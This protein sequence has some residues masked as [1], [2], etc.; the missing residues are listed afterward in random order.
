MPFLTPNRTLGNNSGNNYLVF[1][2]FSGKNFG[3]ANKVGRK[4]KHFKL[5]NGEYLNGVSYDAKQKRYRI[6]ATGQRFRADT[7]SELTWKFNELTKQSP[8]QTKFL[9]GLKPLTKEESAAIDSEEINQYKNSEYAFKNDKEYYAKVAADITA[10][11]KLMAEKTGIEQLGYLKGLKPLEIPTLE[12]FREI[13]KNEVQVSNGHK[14]AVLRAWDDFVKT[15]EIKALDDINEKICVAYAKTVN[16]R[17]QKNSYKAHTFKYIRT[18]V[19]FVK[20]QAIAMDFMQ[21]LIEKMSLLKVKGE[22]KDQKPIPLTKD[23]WEKLYKN[24]EGFE[25]ALILVML[26]GGFHLGEAL[27]L[28]WSEIKDGAIVTNRTK[29]K[30]VIRAFYLWEETKQALTAIKN[31]TDYLFISK[32]GTKFSKQGAD[33]RWW[34]LC[35]KA[36]LDLQAKQ[37]RYSAASAMINAN[38]SADQRK[39]LLGHSHETE[40]YY[41]QLKPDATKSAVEAIHKYYFE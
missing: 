23:E 38:I 1:L 39:T 24:A 33:K 9:N 7:E 16:A 26:N 29:Q 5:S 36:G 37:L 19:S 40:D 10:N 22:I 20:S 13:Y 18:I 3:M 27:K 11:P 21:K 30:Q 6:I 31:K 15:T 14:T 41:I 32:T 12:K 34:D 2:P 8:D 35:K 4:A 25:K 17:N 28:K